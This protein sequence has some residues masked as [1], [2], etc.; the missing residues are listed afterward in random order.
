MLFPTCA[1]IASILV[2]SAF[3]EFLQTPRHHDLPDLYEATFAEL[4]HGLDKG[5]YTSVDL[6]KAY[7]ARIEEVNKQGANLSAII[8]TSPVAL[9]AAAHAD[10]LRKH[11]KALGPLHGLPFV[12]KDNYD[13]Q[14]EDGMN[15]TA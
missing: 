12:V 3:G 9:D 7:F 15:T 11:G 6:V 14:Y 4:Q 8:Q 5:H 10:K 1:L 2:A 13:T